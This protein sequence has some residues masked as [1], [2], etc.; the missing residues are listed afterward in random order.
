VL[1]TSGAAR[2]ASALSVDDFVKKTSLIACS[3]QLFAEAADD[4]IR[5]AE[6]EGLH[7]HARSVAVRC[8]N[9]HLGTGS[10]PAGGD[11]PR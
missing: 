9:G 8:K 10:H 6:A 7:A 1:P 5:L 4:V 3:P 11:E 2:F